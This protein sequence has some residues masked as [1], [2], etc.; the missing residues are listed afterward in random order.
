MQK[1]PV[2][3]AIRLENAL[4]DIVD[5]EQILSQVETSDVF[6]AFTTKEK[7]QCR[8]V[9]GRLRELIDDLTQDPAQEQRAS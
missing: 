2:H 3:R 9:L 5:A 8:D 1:K 7:A 6:Q 4:A